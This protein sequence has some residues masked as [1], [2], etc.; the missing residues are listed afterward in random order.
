[1][2]LS[3]HQPLS[4]AALNLI[5]LVFVFFYEDIRENTTDDSEGFK[6]GIL[7]PSILSSRIQSSYYVV[8]VRHVPGTSS[9]S[10]LSNY[11]LCNC[12]DN[13]Y[14]FI[15]V[16]VMLILASQRIETLFF[17]EDP[18]DVPTKRGAKPS[19]VEWII[20]AWVSGKCS[21]NI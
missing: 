13:M 20:L 14:I 19:L 10:T 6:P 15:L 9:L 11:Y 21:K 18:N 12:E 7:H 16:S 2:R 5:E 17:D 4:T 8:V 1:M 3:V